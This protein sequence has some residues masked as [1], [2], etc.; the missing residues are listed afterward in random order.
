MNDAA[1][2][3]MLIGGAYLVG[4]V[5]FGLLLGKLNGVDIREHGSGNIGAT[6]LLRVCGRRVGYVGFALDVAKGAAPVLA[7]GLAT[8]LLGLGAARGEPDAAGV[9]EPLR[10]AELGLWIAVGVAAMLG[11]IFPVYL[12]FK[13]GKGVATGLGLF[14]AFWP[15]TTIPAAAS[16]AVW[17]A[18]VRTTRYVSVASMAAAVALPTVALVQMLLGWPI[19][20]RAIDRATGGDGD[21]VGAADGL[22]AAGAGVGSASSISVGWPFLVMTLTL[23]ALV[24]A[25]HRSNI[26]RLRAGTESKIGST[27]PATPTPTPMPSDGA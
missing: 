19:P 20:R 11:H 5:P 18:T 8:G 21:A 25:K 10:A 13:G 6:N 15:W 12:R 1:L 7:A 14:L 4:S 23:A 22:S 3:A 17:I 27:K 2:W 9:V 16:L 26:A 24:I